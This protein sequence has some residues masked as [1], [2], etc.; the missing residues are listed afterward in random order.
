MERVDEDPFDRRAVIDPRIGV[1]VKEERQMKS[2][3]SLTD[4]LLRETFCDWRMDR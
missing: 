4:Y 1:L 2:A 3:L